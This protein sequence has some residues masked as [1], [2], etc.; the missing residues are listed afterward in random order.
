MNCY[1]S[2]RYFVYRLFLRDGDLTTDIIRNWAFTIHPLLR[3]DIYKFIIIRKEYISLGLLVLN[4]KNILPIDLEEDIGIRNVSNPLLL[5][6]E[7][8]KY[9]E[10][11]YPYYKNFVPSNIAIFRF[12]IEDKWDYKDIF[13]PIGESNYIGYIDF[14]TK[15]IGCSTE[16][17]TVLYRI[18]N[19]E[20]FYGKKKPRK[21][22]L[23][24]ERAK[25]FE[26]KSNR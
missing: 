2:T 18:F 24:S 20:R 19:G 22:F 10:V 7:T 3:N 14:S 5:R 26:N 4:D 12:L 21:L 1:E 25:I 15:I 23:S 6:I 11:I 9:H 8:L 16:D 13:H 17:L